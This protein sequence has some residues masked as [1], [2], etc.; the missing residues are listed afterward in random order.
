MPSDRS[1]VPL[2]L[3]GR[4]RPSNELIAEVQSC[5]VLGPFGADGFGGCPIGAGGR[6]GGAGAFGAGVGAGVRVIGEVGT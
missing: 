2:G 1:P 4:A 5:V 3:D 6:A